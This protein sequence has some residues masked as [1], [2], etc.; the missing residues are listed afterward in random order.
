[1]PA[2]H[3]IYIHAHITSTWHEIILTA[4]SY[5]MSDIMLL[6]DIKCDIL[7]FLYLIIEACRNMVA[8]SLRYKTDSRVHFFFRF[9]KWYLPNLSLQRLTTYMIVYT[10][11]SSSDF[12]IEKIFLL[13][14]NWD[15]AWGRRWC[16]DKTDGPYPSISSVP[17]ESMNNGLAWELSSPWRTENVA[18]SISLHRIDRLSST[19]GIWLWCAMLWTISHPRHKTV[20]KDGSR[21]CR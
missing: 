10:Y 18:H 15:V 16:C 9:I 5:R 20:D 6:L 2:T 13:H 3:S 12:H 14:Y 8:R 17:R 11:T 19:K 21:H 1:M 7:D 4:W